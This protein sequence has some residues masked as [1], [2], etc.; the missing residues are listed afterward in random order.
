VDEQVAFCGKSGMCLLR[1]GYVADALS[2]TSISQAS[3]ALPA[4]QNPHTVSPSHSGIEMPPAIL[5][6]RGRG[7]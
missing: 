5:I 4:L 3:D 6:P 1:V 7:N 2:Y